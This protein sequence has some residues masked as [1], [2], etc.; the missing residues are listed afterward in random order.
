MAQ[1][2]VRTTPLEVLYSRSGSKVCLP[3]Q[4]AVEDPL[5]TNAQL[6]IFT[7]QLQPISPL[8]SRISPLS[9]GDADMEKK[10]NSVGKLINC[11]A[12]ILCR[13]IICLAEGFSLACN[14]LIS[15]WLIKEKGREG[16]GAESREA[17]DVRG[18][19][20]IHITQG[21]GK[22]LLGLL[23]L[24]IRSLPVLQQ[25]VRNRESPLFTERNI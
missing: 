5:I 7:S 11:A 23:L 13:I 6:Q 21:S 2:P 17:D 4:P 1:A 15:S 8:K 24:F 14:S 16:G 25:S 20:S 10:I 3:K 9:T 12:L 22:P 19:V 18:L